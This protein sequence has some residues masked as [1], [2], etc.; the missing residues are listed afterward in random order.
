MEHFFYTLVRTSATK[1]MGADQGRRG[2]NPFD[3]LQISGS[4]TEH[5][6]LGKNLCNISLW[7]TFG[8]G[9]GNQRP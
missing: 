6:G 7:Q 9:F 3:G 4:T 2:F 5:L 1:D 8:C